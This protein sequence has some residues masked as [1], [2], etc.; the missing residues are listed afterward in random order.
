MTRIFFL[1]PGFMILLSGPCLDGPG[2]RRSTAAQAD[3]HSDQNFNRTQPADVFKSAA[4][5]AINTR[6][7]EFFPKSGP[8]L[9]TVM[10]QCFGML[11]GRGL[12]CK[13]Q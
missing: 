6:T 4:G 12:L 11:S 1:C 13:I 10:I 8:G 9:L 5:G 2:S 7:G 3:T